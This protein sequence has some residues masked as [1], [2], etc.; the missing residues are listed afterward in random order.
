MTGGNSGMGLETARLFAEHGAQ[1]I[2]TGRRKEELDNAVTYIGQNAIGV[3]GDVAN[4]TDLDN[5]YSTIKDKFGRLDIIFANAGVAELAPLSHATEDHFDKIFD[6]NV[7]GLFFTV[8]KAVPLLSEGASIILNSSIS[9]YTGMQNFSV[10]SASKAAVRSFARS[11]SNDLKD[12]KIR[13]NA[14]SPGPIETPIFGK[15]GLTEEQISGFVEA[16]IP[17]IPAGRIGKSEE[18]ATSVLFL[19]SSDSSYITGINLTVSGG[20]AQV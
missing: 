19:A 5:L 2:I 7:K 12:K 13:V 1:V 17:Q 6:I 20:M 8:Q 18:I 3:Q 15:S 16:M 11:W 9:G 14:I 4:L 10:Y